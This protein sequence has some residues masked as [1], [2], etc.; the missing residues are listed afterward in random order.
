MK[1][2]HVWISAAAILLAILIGTSV[3]FGIYGWS[4]LTTY[5]EIWRECHPIWKELAL[6]KIVSG[7]SAA[8]TTSRWPPIRTEHFGP[9]T[10]YWYSEA[11]S[12]TGL[13]VVAVGDRLVGADAGSCTW[14]HTFFFDE[15]ERANIDSEDDRYL[16]TLFKEAK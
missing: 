7:D 14:T 5:R 2:K 4:D 16:Q 9:Y 6:R 12:F 13:R 15:K 11:G 1:R 8:S 3:F 10:T